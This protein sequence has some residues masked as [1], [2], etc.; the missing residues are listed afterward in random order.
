MLFQ[1]KSNPRTANDQYQ[2]CRDHYNKF[3]TQQ[4]P[5]TMDFKEWEKI[6]LTI[7]KVEAYLKQVLKKQ[8][9]TPEDKIELVKTDYTIKLKAYSRKVALRLPETR[10]WKINH[11]VRTG[12]TELG[13]DIDRVVGGKLS[14]LLAQK[15]R[16][17]YR[18]EQDFQEM[19]SIPEISSFLTY[20]G[21]FIGS[22]KKRYSLPV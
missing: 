2:K 1:I 22:D 20:R 8:Y 13:I 5:Q 21:K 11:L 10:E 3:K 19:E 4:Q 9:I 14:K 16:E 17:F 12:E 18:Q 7:P 15:I 6:R